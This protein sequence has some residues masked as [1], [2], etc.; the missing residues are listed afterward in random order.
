MRTT[1]DDV[2]VLL[3]YPSYFE[4]T[5]Q[6][7][8]NSRDVILEKLEQDRLIEKEQG[9]F[10][11]VKNLGALLFAKNLQEFETLRNNTVRVIEYSGEDRTQTIREQEG[12]KVMLP[13]F[14]KSLIILIASFH[15]MK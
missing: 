15:R 6:S 8:P 12:K 5:K 9:G 1:A 14:K 13:V 10:Y 3:D 2:L 7:L 4:L 11:S